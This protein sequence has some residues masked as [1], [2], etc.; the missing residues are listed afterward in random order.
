MD[1]FMESQRNMQPVNEPEELEEPID[2]LVL[3][4]GKRV[5][6]FYPSEGFDL[7]GE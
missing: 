7:G 1:G 6:Y 3:F 2:F 4:L 5:T